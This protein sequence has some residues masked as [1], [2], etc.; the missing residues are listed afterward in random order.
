M[1]LW[2]RALEI[3]SIFRPSVT[4]AMDTRKS[5][6]PAVRRIVRYLD[7]CVWD[8]TVRKTLNLFHS[9]PWWFLFSLIPN[10]RNQLDAGTTK[11]VLRNLRYS[12]SRWRQPDRWSDHSDYFTKPP[13]LREISGCSFWAIKKNQGYSQSP[14]SLF[15]TNWRAT[16]AYRSFVYL[17]I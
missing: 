1:S 2:H 11:K 8:L 15:F 4:S 10:L 14:E 6:S 7:I 17:Q 5:Y 13:K 9:Q 16:R 12:S 3:A